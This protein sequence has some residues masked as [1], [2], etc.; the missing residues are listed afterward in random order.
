[1]GI[2]AVLVTAARLQFGVN[3]KSFVSAAAQGRRIK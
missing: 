3:L 2:M 1:M